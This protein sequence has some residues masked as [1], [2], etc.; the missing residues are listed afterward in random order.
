MCGEEWVFFNAAQ[1]LP[2]YVIQLHESRKPRR[3]K[4]PPPMAA[5]LLQQQRQDDDED[6]VSERERERQKKDK[7]MARVSILKFCAC[8][9]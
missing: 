6:D 5:S 3:D 7:L 8:L 2:C 4:L 1:V 9:L